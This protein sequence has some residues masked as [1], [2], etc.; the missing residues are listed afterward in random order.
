M[1]KQLLPALRATFILAFITGIMYPVVLTGIAQV[2]FP[3]QANGSLIRSESGVVIGSKLIGQPFEKPQYFHPR[4]SAAG[5]GYAGEASS[6]TNLGPTS[7]KLIEGQGSGNPRTSD[8]FAGIKQLAERYRQD[9]ALPVDTAVPVDAV[10]RSASGLDP[11]ISVGNARMQAARVAKS[12]NLPLERVQQMVRRYT[13]ER[14]LSILGEP[15]VNVLML[16][17]ALDKL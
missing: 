3:E 14:D 1:F 8:Y 17:L 15:R 4:P 11:H 10:T 12:R 13:E 6:G 2:L 5:S 16:N 9:N 7:R